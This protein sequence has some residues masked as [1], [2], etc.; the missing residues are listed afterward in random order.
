MAGI[1]FLKT[2]NKEKVREFYT[3]KINMIVWLEQKDCVVL[4]HG[5]LLLGLCA[6]DEIDTQ[7][8][9][10]FF[11]STREEVD[12]MYDKLEECEKAEPKVNDKYQIYHFF[13]KY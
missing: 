5:N 12:N 2:R 1:F 6:R 7:G 10:T 3:K 11:Y 9:I 13:A 4:K 8:I